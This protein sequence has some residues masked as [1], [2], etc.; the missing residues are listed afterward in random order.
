LSRSSR[1]G[2]EG[3]SDSSTYLGVRVWG[4]AKL[5][6]TRGSEILHIFIKNTLKMK[7]LN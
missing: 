5:N 6:E 4:Q 7:H 2:F 3:A 1:C